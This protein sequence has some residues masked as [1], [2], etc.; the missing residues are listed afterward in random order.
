MEAAE[1]TSPLV[2]RQ[3]L[4]EHATASLRT[5]V[6][7]LS[8]P[9]GVGKSALARGIASA[10]AGP[11]RLLDLHEAPHLTDALADAGADGRPLAVG[12]L[13][14]VLGPEGLLVLDGA[15]ADVPTQAELR[16]LARRTHVL[17]T[18][19]DRI[20]N[21]RILP[22]PPLPTEDARSLLS[23]HLEREGVD[24]D[25]ALLDRALE[26]TDG[27]PG[28]LAVLA[29]QL[30]LFG[31]A[32]LDPSLRTPQDRVRYALDQLDPDRRAMAT[33]W[34]VMEASFEVFC[35]AA[36]ADVEL[37][38][39]AAGLRLLVTRGL[40]LTEASRFRLLRDARELLRVGVGPEPRE[41]LLD[42]ICSDRMSFL[43]D[44]GV[45][46]HRHRRDLLAAV[47]S[48][49]ERLLVPLSRAI[50]E[51]IETVAP[52]HLLE[53]LKTLEAR[54]ND[55]R[56]RLRRFW[57]QRL[58]HGPA[59]VELDRAWLEGLA[60]QGELDAMAIVWA[61]LPHRSPEARALLAEMLEREPDPAATLLFLPAM[62]SVSMEPE[63][64]ERHIRPL[65]AFARMEGLA[66]AQEIIELAHLRCLARAE[67]LERVASTPLRP[68]EGCA[69]VRQRV[70]F[71]LPIVYSRYLLGTLD[72]VPLPEE[73]VGLTRL[74][75]MASLHQ[76]GTDRAA[77]ERLARTDGDPFVAEAAD[78]LLAHLD[79][80]G[81]NLA[82]PSRLAMWTGEIHGERPKSLFVRCV[83]AFFRQSREM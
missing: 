6:T 7:T 1:T 12:E 76:G 81:P 3:E 51:L 32:A 24:L 40:C 10:W 56:I 66:Y 14:D 83:A 21:T 52:A 59:A 77:Y 2:G 4:L 29:P 9:I 49:A 80:A 33:A 74:W 42:W 54:S 73:P 16:E 17:C 68:Y 63:D 39:A 69:W 60:A 36:V 65:E 30:A 45:R 5:G 18:S 26:R 44:G 75:L 72:A 82:T 38:E 64:F 15:H 25:D 62:L 48:C 47:D 28:E 71:N 34:S 43:R 27:L 67:R 8:G 13:I 79:G 53:P 55:P 19:R 58:G 31:E 46:G 41:R 35:A 61:E 22:V 37:A 57:V 50:E 11:C 20:A 70:S 78:L 23:T